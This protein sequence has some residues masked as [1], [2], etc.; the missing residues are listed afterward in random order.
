MSAGTGT[1]PDAIVPFMQ[2]IGL[3][4][5]RDTDDGRF[6]PPSVELACLITG[7]RPR[8]DHFAGVHLGTVSPGHDACA[9]Q[10][11]GPGPAGGRRA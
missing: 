1:Q 2:A 4:R 8:P 5:Y 10:D 11:G 3:G 9:Y 6:L 7:L